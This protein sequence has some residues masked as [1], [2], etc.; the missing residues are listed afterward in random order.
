MRRR[1]AKLVLGLLVTAIPLVGS[2]SALGVNAPQSVIVSPNPVDNTPQVLGSPDEQVEA[3]AQIGNTVY[4]GGKFTRE[5]ETPTGD[6]FRRSWLFAYDA[7]TGMIV[8]KFHP[9][10]DARVYAIAVAPA[11]NALFIGGE[12]HFIDGVE[13][14]FVAKIDAVT[15]APVKTWGV[16]IYDSVRDVIVRNDTV[17]IAGDFEKVDGSPRVGLAALDAETANVRA[18]LDVPFTNQRKGPQPVV[19]KIDITPDGSTLVAVGNFT[20][21]GGL[22]RTELAVL[23]LTTAPASVANWETDRWKA[24]CIP[25]EDSY[26]QDV[27]ISPDGS[28]FVTVSIGYFYPGTLC[29]AAARW[30]ID[31]T[32]SKI[33]PTWV[34]YTGGDSLLSVAVTGTAVYVGGHQRWMNNPFA[35]GVAG[36]GGVPREGIAALDP[37]NGLPYSWNPGRSRGNGV[38]VQYASHEGLYLG[39]D[40]DRLGGE[41]HSKFGF[42]PVDGGEAVPRAVSG[43]VPGRL[44]RMGYD[45]G[46][47]RGRPFDGSSFGDAT[48]AAPL[49]D[50]SQAR[51]A[52]MVNGILYTAWSDGHVYARTFDGSTTGPPVDL[53]TTS[54][55]AAGATN[56][57]RITGM[58]FKHGRIFY[59]ARHDRR[60]HYRYFTPE[61]GV[62]GAEQFNVRRTSAIVNWRHVRG[63]TLASGKLYFAT[64]EAGD[65]HDGNLYSMTWRR[66]HPIAGTQER[67]SGPDVDGISWK[68]RGLFIY[69]P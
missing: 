23:D 26:A 43:S 7:T 25:S 21:V 56:P 19:K 55:D 40:T 33:Q 11:G 6:V 60:M 47:L 17:Y 50:W 31:Q 65:A 61:S 51:G 32:G 29:D 63:M 59:T 37:V 52:F 10:I 48:D 42:F 66:N 15:G 13:K 30:E 64:D 36:P 34:D 67:I 16:R 12:F 68:S 62:I 54:F 41:Y 49:T 3:V 27:D 2:P 39:T 24:Q 20:K 58:F 38:F 44:F 14:D 18:N 4:V 45:D 46:V 8:K 5:Q 1:F 22:D 57:A 35:T 69:S 9:H 28:Y 53:A